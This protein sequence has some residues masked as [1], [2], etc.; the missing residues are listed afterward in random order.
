MSL[1]GTHGLGI[2]RNICPSLMAAAAASRPSAPVSARRVESG[3]RVLTFVRNAAPSIPGIRMSETTTAA[4]PF[5]LSTARPST[6]LVAVYRIDVAGAPASGSRR[7]WVGVE[8]RGLWGVQFQAYPA[9][10]VT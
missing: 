4:P 6:P 10:E 8:R 9:D 1:S 7:R 3:Q 5:C 2:N